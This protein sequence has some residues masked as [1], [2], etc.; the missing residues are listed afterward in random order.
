MVFTS[1]HGA[2]LT[3][4]WVWFL[5][6]D[7]YTVRDFL[8]L[9]LVYLGNSKNVVRCEVVKAGAKFLEDSLADNLFPVFYHSD[10]SIPWRVFAP[11]LFGVLS[12]TRIFEIV[13]TFFSD[14]RD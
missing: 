14:F 8:E 10:T 3:F 7:M 5:R 9:C 12:I 1:F 6:G 2:Y 11:F 13:K 4:F